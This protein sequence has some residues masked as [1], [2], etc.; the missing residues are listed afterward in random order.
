MIINS[1]NLSTAANTLIHDLEIGDPSA[2]HYLAQ[3]IESDE[4]GALQPFA[5][6]LAARLQDHLDRW[7]ELGE[8]DP[9]ITLGDDVYNLLKNAS[10]DWDGMVHPGRPG[11]EA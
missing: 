1:T 8:T 2:S 5:D 7:A 4:K 11:E 3:I 10:I 6:A 9:Q